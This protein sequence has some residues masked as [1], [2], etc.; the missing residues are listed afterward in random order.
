[1]SSAAAR[2]FTLIELLVV[3]AIIALLAGM[4]AAVLP[5]AL[6]RARITDV[7]SDFNQIRTAMVEY[8]T[9][10]D[11]YPSAYG[12]YTGRDK[13]DTFLTPYTQ[14]L[15]I[16][17]QEDLYDRF[18]STEDTDGNGLISLLEYTRPFIKAPDG[19]IVFNPTGVNPLTS[20]PLDPNVLYSTGSR[21]PNDGIRPYIY[22]PVYMNHVSKVRTYF[23]QNGQL[24]LGAL[25]PNGSG[26]PASLT[27]ELGMIPPPRYDGFVLMSVG[28]AA[29]TGTAGLLQDIRIEGDVTPQE[30]YYINTLH[31]YFLATRD[32]D[33]DDR[34]DFD[35]EARGRGGQNWEF[36]EQDPVLSQGPSYTGAQGPMIYRYP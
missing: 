18:S 9:R 31:A 2:G 15:G 5:R 3:I 23:F 27:R 30:R 19:S 11:S 28:P 8:Y 14:R 6:E 29:N 25:D 13:G 22:L 21:P 7:R 36:P 35:F 16:T 12:F 1:M 20:P 17:G 32:W 4:T 10:H 24:A 26:W 33:G 34:L